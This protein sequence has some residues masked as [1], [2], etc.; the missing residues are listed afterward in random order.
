MWRKCFPVKRP[1]EPT[2]ERRWCWRNYTNAEANGTLTGP[3]VNCINNISLALVC[4]FSSLLILKGQ[5]KLG[6]LSSFVQYSRKFS[7][8]INEFANIMAEIQSAFAAAASKAAAPAKPFA[9]KRFVI[10]V[11]NPLFTKPAL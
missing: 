7:G 9:L 6:D 11:L 10:E 1:S 2:A 8:P 4:I 3:S 5:L